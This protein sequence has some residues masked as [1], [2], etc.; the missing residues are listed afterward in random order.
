MFQR[1]L[2]ALEYPRWEQFK[3]AE[4]D[5]FRA[6]IVWLE[7][8][9]IRH[10]DESE[11]RSMRLI[12]SP[13]WNQT[14]HKYLQSLE[15]SRPHSA[16][17][18]APELAFVLDYLLSVAVSAEFADKKEFLSMDALRAPP[19]H[20]QPQVQTTATAQAAQA[21]QRAQNQP[22]FKRTQP[23]HPNIQKGIE[24]LPTLSC[25]SQEFSQA[26][27]ILATAFNLPAKY[28]EVVS[29]DFSL[30]QAVS[31]RIRQTKQL[32]NNTAP[33]T[34]AEAL[35]LLQQ[36]KLGF[37]LQNASVDHAATLLRLLYIS[38]LRDLQTQINSLITTAQSFT[39]DPKTDARL[40]KVGY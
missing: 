25:S 30:L 21:G 4:Q 22:K 14:F 20:M 24:P 19:V 39:A 37:S 17:M 23:A 38:D 29:S 6:L 16:Q 36:T 7:E 26:V 33:L 35:A 11:R 15:C 40:G 32:S 5:Q 34:R 3:I 28:G 27:R 9:K 31:Q 8:T 13:A 1:K 2:R 10:L 12:A 18:S